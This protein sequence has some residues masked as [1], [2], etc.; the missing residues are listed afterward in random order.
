MPTCVPIATIGWCYTSRA[1]RS[2]SFTRI[3]PLSSQNDFVPKDIVTNP[4]GGR[5]GIPEG[6]LIA[7]LIAHL[8]DHFASKGGA[9]VATRDYHPHDHA[10]FLSQGGPFPAHCI[11]GT[12]VAACVQPLTIPPTA[13]IR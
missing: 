3:V 2:V 4:T 12:R 7:P 10:S 13:G 1:C 5:F 8:I 9:V 11:Q 6:D